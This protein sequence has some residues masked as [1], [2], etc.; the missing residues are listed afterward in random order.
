MTGFLQWGI[1]DDQYSNVLRDKE[2][3]QWL[4]SR[5]P[6][7]AVQKRSSSLETVVYI[8]WVSSHLHLWFVQHWLLFIAVSRW[9]RKSE[10]HEWSLFEKKQKKTKRCL[11]NTRCSENERIEMSFTSITVYCIECFYSLENCWHN[12]YSLRAFCWVGCLK[13]TLVQVSWQENPPGFTSAQGC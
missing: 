6:F 12:L 9:K 3:N 5:S 10:S 8:A 13:G 7:K 2:Y 4:Y 1:S 11:V